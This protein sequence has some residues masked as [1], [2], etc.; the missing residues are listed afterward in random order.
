[1]RKAIVGLA[2]LGAVTMGTSVQAGSLRGS[3]AGQPDTSDRGMV[4]PVYWGGDDCGPRCQEHRWREHERWAAHRRWEQHRWE[5][6]H[7]GY[8]AHPQY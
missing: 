3:E 8:Y 4:L 5:E 2:L 7:Y 6:R 1:M